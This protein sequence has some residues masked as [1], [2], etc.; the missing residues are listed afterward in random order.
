MFTSRSVVPSSRTI[1]MTG[2]ILVV[3]VAAAQAQNR[4]FSDPGRVFRTPAP[5]TTKK[6]ASKAS[7][8]RLF[9]APAATWTEGV[10]EFGGQ[11]RYENDNLLGNMPLALSGTVASTRTTT[12]GATTS[13]SS[14]GIGAEL[15]PY[16]NGR[17]SLVMTGSMNKMA[18]VG[19][20]MEFAP[21][22]DVMVNE[23]L[24]VAPVMYWNRFKLDGAGAPD[25]ETGTT[26]GVI[27]YLTYNS[28]AA[29]PEYDFSSDWIGNKPV[30]SVKVVKS[31]ANMSRDPRLFVGLERSDIPDSKN[32]FTAGI[33]LS[34]H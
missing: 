1:G 29:Y 5:A 6:A 12:A 28:W 22:L 32:I 30:Y 31:F 25:A 21:E 20:T 2:L 27:G 14:Y 7:S 34:L 9:L 16:T 26:Y 10:K 17:F 18:D 8:Y 15:D 11:V 4:N 24:T 13:K 3:S 33:R 23:H 19:T